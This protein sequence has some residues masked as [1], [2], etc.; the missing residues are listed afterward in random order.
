MP[1]AILRFQKK[2]TGG[3]TA[4]YN[5]NERKKSAYKSNPDIS[6]E[7]EP[8]NYHLILPKQTYHREVKRL[9]SAA[10][11]RTRANSTVMV[12]TLITASPEFMQALKPPE[13]REYFARALAFMESKIGKENIVAAVVHMDEKTPHM[14]LSFCPIAPGKNGLTLSAKAILGNQAQLSKWQDDFHNFM[15]ARWT[16]LE[17]GISSQITNRKHIPVSLFKNADFDRD[18]ALLD[19]QRDAYQETHKLRRQVRNQ[20]SLIGNLPFEVRRELLE[21][22]KKQREGGQKR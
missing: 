5:H 4:A 13:Q 1:Y 6:S 11:C 20:E 16:E 12:E 15:S 17:R 2:K 3:V 18:K 8:D 22:M 9:I 21:K 19:A 10:K 14:H 7:R